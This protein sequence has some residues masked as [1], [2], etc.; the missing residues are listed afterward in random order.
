MSDTGTGDTGTGTGVA[1]IDD[2]ERARRAN[3]A[4]DLLPA[5]ESAGV[6]GVVIGFVDLT[7][8]HRVKTVPLSRLPDAAARGVGISVSFDVFGTDDIPVPAAGAGGSVGD[9][10]LHPDVERVVALSAMPGWAWAPGD[11]YAQDGTPHPL[12]ARVALHRAVDALAA[13]GLTA[14]AAV[15]VEWVFGTEDD[16]PWGAPVPPTQGNAYGMTRLVDTAEVLGDLM[17]ALG[18]CG[19]EVGQIHPE[20]G[21]GQFE[22]SVAA[23]DPVAAAD[24]SVLVRQTVRAVGRDHGLRVSFAPQVSVGG[25]GNGGHVHLS[26]SRAGTNLLTGGDGAAGMTAAGESFAA[27]VLAHLPGLLAVGAPA[28]VSW[29]RLVPANWAGAWAVWGVEN[30]EAALRF[31]PGAPG[32]GDRS[33]NLELKSVDLA[34]NPYL[35]LAG[36]L[37]A[38]RAGI[39]GGLTLPAPVSVDPASMSESARSAAGVASLPDGLAAAT[40]ALVADEVLTAGYGPLLTATM[41]AH[42]RAELARFDGMSPEAVTAATRWLW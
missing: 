4:R 33:A 20:Y 23:E 34:A 6:V 9:L 26:V 15:E 25:V 8:T 7:G 28:A 40:D 17:A 27:G 41:V 18:D 35:L 36:M 11:R 3:R 5:L 32:D 16:D 12:D 30:R 37:T 24:T 19:V 21:P 22:V 10:R 1:R 14:R 39:A 42:R 31:V 29:L 2:A 38:G 13:G